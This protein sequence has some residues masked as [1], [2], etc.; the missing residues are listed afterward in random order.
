MSNNYRK[1]ALLI[2]V[3]LLILALVGGVSAQDG[4]MKSVTSAFLG[5]GDVP[6]IDPSKVTD[7]TS[8]SVIGST[9]VGLTLQNEVTAELEPGLAHSWDIDGNHYVFHLREGIRWVRWDMEAGEVVGINDA[10]GNPRYVT[11]HDVVYGWHRT[12]NP[13]TGSEY[14]YVLAEWVEGAA[15]YNN[16]MNDDFASVGITAMDDYTLSIHATAANAF[17]PAIFGMWMALPQLQEVVEAYGDEWIEA[18]T[19]PSYGPFALKEW[20]HDESL[21]LVANP[22]WEGNEYVP[23]PAIDSVTWLILPASGQLDAYEAGELDIVTSVPVSELDRIRADPMLSEELNITYDTCSYYYGFNTAKEPLDNVHLRRALSFAIDRQALVDNILKAGQ[24]PAQWF[25]RPGLAAA[26]TLETHPDLGIWFDV[27]EAQAELAMALEM[28]GISDPSE[29]EQITLMHNTSETHAALAQAIQ[30]MWS[31]TLGIDVNI[32]NQE[33]A[34]YLTTVRDDAPQIYR[35]GWCADYL[36]A[37]NYNS[38]VWRSTSDFNDT[39]W[40]S[41]EYD[42]LVDTAVRLTDV[43]ERRELYAQ[44]ENIL[45]YEDAAISPIYWYTNVQMTK[46]HIER[47][48]SVLFQ[49][50]YDKW[51]VGE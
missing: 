23:V 4:E 22:Y 19:Y 40:G 20:L 28:D 8:I 41:E 14:A 35:L 49:E 25:A 51:D 33:W 48:F 2:G 1:Q 34:V 9:Y 16:G 36:D 31:E 39:N 7:T 5:P 17:V 45:V 44:A 3:S 18:G 15:D 37:H 32:A 11:A 12:L 13:E 24:I 47:T 10:D 50:R 46:P 21:T 30:Q 42:E 27:E 43:D 26:P 6:S 38:D 29:W